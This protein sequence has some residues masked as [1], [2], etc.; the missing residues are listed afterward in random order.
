MSDEIYGK[1]RFPEIAEDGHGLGVAPVRSGPRDILHSPSQSEKDWAFAK[2]AL[3]RGD[4]EDTVIKAI[5]H[6]RESEKPNPHYYAELTV[7][8]AAQALDAERGDQPVKIS[9]PDR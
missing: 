8:K 3:A 1:E 5:E 6:Y 4:S 7:R 2:R 9:T